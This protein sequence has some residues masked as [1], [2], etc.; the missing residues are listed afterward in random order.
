[1]TWV[2][3][4]G[5]KLRK[6]K[7]I[8]LL[9]LFA[10]SVSLI[11][12]QEF[13]PMKNG[14]RV[15]DGFSALVH[16]NYTENGNQRDSEFPG[17]FQETLFSGDQA[18]A[19]KSEPV[20]SGSQYKGKYVMFGPGIGRSYGGLVGV[21]ATLRLGGNVGVGVH[22]GVGYQPDAPVLFSGG[23]KFYPFRGIYI[24]AQFGV[25]DR[26]SDPYYYDPYYYDFE[27]IRRYTYGPSLLGG[28]EWTWGRTVRFGFNAAFGVSVEI[29]NTLYSSY[30]ISPAV[31]MG[32]AIS[33]PFGSS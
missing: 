8:L 20:Q 9:L 10:S 4:C 25:I 30:S 14:N 33:I 13:I 1:M 28:I 21:S 19:K 32:F 7:R 18:K 2:L 26:Y 24:D 5:S 23:V 27:E 11:L 15:K 31:D 22:G 12:A 6:M 16:D 3:S 17:S 29:W